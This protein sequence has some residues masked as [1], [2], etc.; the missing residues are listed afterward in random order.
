LKPIILGTAGHIDHGK[1][2]LIK[3]V[4]GVNTDRLKEEKLRGIT[5]ELGFASLHLP[6]GQKLGV[7]DVP[8]HEKFVKNM[9]AGATGIDIV[10]MVIAADE[11]IM[12]Q[13]REHMEICT[14]LD[15][16]HGMIVLTKSDLVDDEWLEMVRDEVSDFARDTFLEGAPVIPVSSTTGQGLPEFLQAL[17]Q[18]SAKVAAKVTSGLFRLPVDRVFTM[19]GF[20][21]VITGTLISGKV[22]V[23][24]R[25]MVYPSGITSKV[26][27]IQV[28]GESTETAR[29]G[30]RTAINFQGL[31][32]E[33]VGRGDMVA[34]PDALISSH[35]L[36][37]SLT[38]LPS[39]P[40]KLKN[41]TRVRFH[42]GT[43]EIMGI[44]VLLDCDALDGGQTVMAQ[45]RLESPVSLIR[46]D[47]YVLRSYSPVQ[48]I[49]GGR[50]L[51]PVPLKHKPQKPGVMEHLTALASDDPEQVVEQFIK[52]AG[53]RGIRHHHLRIMVNIPDKHLEKML[54][55]M[56]SKKVII[57]IDK[58]T[59]TLIH[60][61]VFSDIRQI[62]QDRM[63]DY[64]QTFP[65]KPGIPKEELKSKLPPTI[66][67]K[68]FLIALQHMV[69]E[70]S[71]ILEKDIV[72]MAD[73]KVTLEVDQQDLKNKIL[74][75]YVEG[76]LSPPW[77]KEICQ[78]LEAPK[79]TA[80]EVLSLLIKEGTLVKVKED[81]YYHRMHL[82]KL[83]G[84]LVEY[85]IANEE[86]TTPQFKDMTG[87]SRK[88]VIPLIEYFDRMQLTIRV[89]DIRKLRRLPE[90]KLPPLDNT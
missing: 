86:I 73:H 22:S 60:Q 66:G 27:G 14:L 79:Q 63:R 29:A 5:I 1:T 56:L 77:F 24:E 89:G 31:D 25:I 21:T 17:E 19:R 46:D 9:V 88:Y 76:N 78:N 84:Q 41:R 2:S 33:K 13:T 47:R 28:H 42:S 12:P 23:G 16:R 8:G 58:D 70:A 49:G 83:K 50:I 48:T 26:R 53:F 81:Q 52:A 67:A 35:M 51:N 7:V 75:A 62:I 4:T 64:H 34:A 36:D 38:Y 54:Q 30:M 11:G 85:L 37:V 32:K 82:D 90:N 68:T 80:K 39:N 72:F 3:A 43:S 45:I 55:S 74:A 59:R 20:G 44:V 57:R 71:I 87:V 61:N 18:I 10:A 15:I 40:K 6:G 65:L 69:K